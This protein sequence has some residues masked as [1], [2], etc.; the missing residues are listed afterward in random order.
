MWMATEKKPLIRPRNIAIALM[1]VIV[2]VIGGYGYF[3]A[4]MGGYLPWQED[5]TPIS[6]DITPFAG[7]GFENLPT[8][9]PKR[10]PTP[11]PTSATSA[12]PAAS[13]DASPIASPEG[14]PAASPETT[15]VEAMQTFAALPQPTACAICG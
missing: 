11:E 13:P 8:T 4:D 14:S 15:D 12:S 2:L 9:P 3:L 6:N 5:P 7:A 1:G 10:T